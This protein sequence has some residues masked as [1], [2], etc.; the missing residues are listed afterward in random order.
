[1]HPSLY[2]AFPR[3]KPIYP[4]YR[5]TDATFRIG[6]QFRITVE[7]D[8]PDDHL[9]TLVHLLDGTRDTRAVVAVMRERFP[10]LTEED[11]EQSIVMLNEEGFLDDARPASYDV[12]GNLS[13]FAGNVNY[14]S[15]YTRLPDDRSDHQDTLRNATVV[16]LGLGGGGSHLLPLLSAAGIGRI[17]AVD[18]DRVE[19]SN[20][21]RQLLYREADIGRYKT[22]AAA[23]AVKQTNSLLELS[24]ITKKIEC[25]DDARPIVR[26]ADL[27]ICAIDEPPFLAQRRVNRACI[28]EGVPCLYGLSQVTSGR[29]FSVLPNQSGCVDCLHLYYSM[30]DVNFVPQFRGFHESNFNPPT[31][32]FAPHIARLCGLIADEAVR[33]LTAYREPQSVAKQVEFDFESGSLTTLTTW[34]RYP[35]ECPTCGDGREQ[36]WPVFALY[37]GAVDRA[38]RP[39]AMAWTARS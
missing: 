1:M 24:T 2:D 31:I 5:V 38:E 7:I 4:V 10:A 34:P 28:T 25:A 30:H 12:D 33:L 3:L 29:M 17:V 8:D 11:I 19:L 13:R 9:W 23:D 36:D 18:Y 22:E 26:G 32:A 15:H 6:A 39:E 27:V 16:L 14:F 37:P 20:L 35:D 21:N